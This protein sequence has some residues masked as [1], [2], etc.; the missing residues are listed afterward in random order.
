[1][2]IKAD[3]K[4]MQEE[5]DVQPIAWVTDDGPDG[6]G[7]RRLLRLEFPWL[8]TFVC[9]AHQS[10]LLAGDYLTSPARSD[11]INAALDI[12]RWFN[13]HS[14][15]LELFQR[16]QQFTYPDRLRPLALIL[17]VVTRWTTHEQSISRLLLLSSA[18]KTCVVRNKA[19]LLEIAAKS[20]TAN[21]AA[22]ALKVI[23][24]VED[25]E[26]WSRLDRYVWNKAIFTS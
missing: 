6:K 7:A 8:M 16:E 10:N 12:I 14:T 18:M 19:R 23:A 13:N 25:S 20:Q 11:V 1:M 26:F 17:P 24:S 9:W 15:A 3:M 4:C 22:M 21:A 5:Y 2:I